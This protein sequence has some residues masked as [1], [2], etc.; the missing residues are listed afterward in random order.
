MKIKKILLCFLLVIFVCPSFVSAV[1]YQSG[2]IKD[3]IVTET[4]NGITITKKVSKTEED[5]VYNVEFAI[6]GEN[7]TQTLVKDVYISVVFDRSGSMLCDSGTTTDK[8]I[9]YTKKTTINNQD[10]YCKFTDEVKLDKWNNAVAGAISF[11]KDIVSNIDS[12]KLNLI[13]FAS[14]INQKLD[15]SNSIFKQEDFGYP[16]GSTNLHL[17]VDKAKSEFDKISGESLKYIV[18]I[19]DG[20]PDN[21]EK[22][23]ASIKNVKDAGIKVYTIGYDTTDF[24]KEI[25]KEISSGDGYYFE[26]NLDGI[27][28]VLKKLAVELDE[29]AS[30]TD[31]VMLD[32]IGKDFSYVNGE[33]VDVLDRQVTY[34]FS[35]ISAE[36]IV[37]DFNIML[38]SNLDTGWYPTNDVTNDGVVLK[39]KDV[40][41]QEQKIVMSSSSLVY[42]EKEKYPY[43]VNYYK[44]FI[45]SENFLGKVDGSQELGSI[46]LS[47]NIDKDKY[48]PVGYHSDDVIITDFTIK[49]KDN[50]INI[51]YSK[52]SYPYHIEYYKN[53][54]SRVNLVAKS[55]DI[56]KDY[57]EIITNDI[58]A[59]DFGSEW[60]NQYKPVG[61][62]DGVVI[63]DNMAIDTEN[64]VIKV[65]Y[66]E[67]DTTFYKIEYYFNGKIDNSKTEIVTDQLVGDI[68][69]QL[70]FDEYSNYVL[71]SVDNYPLSL[72]NDGDS[73]VIKVYY[74]LKDGIILPPDTSVHGNNHSF[75]IV[76]CLF[77]CVASFVF[78]VYKKY[79]FVK[80]LKK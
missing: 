52:R 4:K 33:N 10:L 68:V 65:V 78:I 29:V 69:D 12:A 71:K 53:D 67:E 76:S 32:T 28:E 23:K 9:F 11:S 59:I 34:H 20:D 37:F 43:V 51:I 45:S 24:A 58:I 16:N 39:Y 8:G 49:E 57:G 27:G 60:L 1:D 19:S 35:E 80:K 77:I 22:L 66:L 21:V 26:A 42:Y 47:S 2:D 18:I 75:T 25:L 14:D 63:S 73:N 3:P 72:S 70:K 48:L 38:D 30:G 74:E 50:V 64:N 36:K 46:L 6:E 31:A 15:W 41:N 17:A 7:I 40:N 56:Y 54:T 13:T 79:N 55:K 44:D 61:Y 5:F 62:K